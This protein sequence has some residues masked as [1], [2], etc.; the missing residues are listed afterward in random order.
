MIEINQT[1][2]TAAGTI[3]VYLHKTTSQRGS[4]RTRCA[5]PPWWRLGQC[6]STS[7]LLS[8]LAFRSLSLFSDFCFTL[9]DLWSLLA[10]S[11]LESHLWG[12]PFSFPIL[13]GDCLN[14][15][16]SRQFR[17]TRC[18]SGVTGYNGGGSE[19]GNIRVCFL[20]SVAP[21]AQ[22]ASL[23][24]VS[25]GCELARLNLAGVGREEQCA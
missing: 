1:A 12:K 8:Q 22:R 2:S 18:L 4:F 20:S 21:E 9:S 23:F 10:M 7:W 13:F 19:D 14:K 17:N 15:E 3:S 6:C 24:I 5:Q 11:F 16:G 25:L